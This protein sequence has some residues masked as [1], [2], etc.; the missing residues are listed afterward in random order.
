MSKVT[1][2]TAVLAGLAVSDR[3]NE[4]DVQDEQ[5]AT[6]VGDLAKSLAEVMA[7]TEMVDKAVSITAEQSQ[8]GDTFEVDRGLAA[9]RQVTS[10]L[11]S[12]QEKITEAFMKNATPEEMLLMKLMAALSARG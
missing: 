7:V 3:L 6:L 1:I 4:L 11:V 9:I 2:A 10:N 5:L 12:D 8:K